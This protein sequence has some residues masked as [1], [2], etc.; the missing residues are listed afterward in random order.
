MKL[1]IIDNVMQ[2]KQVR[3]SQVLP[4]IGDAVDNERRPLPVV[5]DIV[6]W[7]QLETIKELNIGLVASVEAIVWM[8]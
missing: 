4:R 1:L 5:T 8:S 6:L 7:P 3:D 2:N